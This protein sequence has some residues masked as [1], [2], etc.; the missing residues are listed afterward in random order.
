M[1]LFPRLLTFLKERFCGIYPVF[2]FI[3]YFKMLPLTPM[4]N[5]RNYFSERRLQL[6]SEPSDHQTLLEPGAVPT[7]FRISPPCS[8]QPRVLQQAKVIFPCLFRSEEY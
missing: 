1:S 5:F 6:A 3:F 2:I 7:A 4:T 8:R